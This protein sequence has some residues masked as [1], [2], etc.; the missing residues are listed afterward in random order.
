MD[1]GSWSSRTQ[2]LLDVAYN[3]T[4]ERLQPSEQ[5]W[6]ANGYGDLEA[7]YAVVDKWMEE[8]RRDGMA[9]LLPVPEEVAWRKWESDDDEI[10]RDEGSFD[11]P[12]ASSL[13]DRSKR[14]RFLLVRR[15]PRSMKYPPTR[16]I[17]IHMAATGAT[18]STIAHILCSG[19]FLKRSA[20]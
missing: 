15:A 12:L 17:M 13:P 3:A 19:T 2:G 18:N 10:W 16:A 20:L 11:S 8:W 6:F 7:Y 4:R 5:R 14:A 1:D 9:D